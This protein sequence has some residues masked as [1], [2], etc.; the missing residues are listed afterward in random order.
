MHALKRAAAR[1]AVLTALVTGAPSLLLAE[2]GVHRAPP[3]VRAK[4][5][6]SLLG[7]AIVGLGLLLLV[8]LSSRYLRRRLRGPHKR[9][10][11]GPDYWAARRLLKRRSKGR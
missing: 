11:F 8:R 10:R 4:L 2:D 6:M 5:W 9:S 1:L 3:V 7:I